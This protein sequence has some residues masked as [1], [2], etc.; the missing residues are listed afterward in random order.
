VIWVSAIA[1]QVLVN[2]DEEVAYLDAKID[3]VKIGED[4]IK[5]VRLPEWEQKINPD[6]LNSHKE[7]N[8][9]MIGEGKVHLELL[10]N[11]RVSKSTFG[12]TSAV[13][14]GDEVFPIG[15]YSQGHYR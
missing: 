9:I 4:W 12:V 7:L 3:S 14:M 5:C 2:V 11:G 13:Y 8:Y 1:D 15:Y 10:Q 6:G